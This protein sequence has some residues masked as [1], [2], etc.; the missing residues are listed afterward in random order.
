MA[1][2]AGGF[3]GCCLYLFCT[4]GSTSAVEATGP[5]I[6]PTAPAIGPSGWLLALLIVIPAV[7]VGLSARPARAIGFK[8]LTLALGWTLIE[9]VLVT[10]HTNTPEP[11]A[12]ARAVSRNREPRASARAGLQSQDYSNTL[13]QG[14][15]TGSQAEAPHLHWLARLLGYVSTAFLV[16]CANASLVGILAGARLSFP[17]QR[18]LSGSLN[19]GAWAPSQVVL[20][21]Q[22]WTLRQAYPRAPPI[23]VAVPNWNKCK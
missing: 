1:A 18:S 16:A 23:L 14:L 19:A 7:Y 13:Q 12:S 17:P 6:D 8:L 20:S 11:Q 4:A 15:L 10:T 21:I 5:A 3:W 9:A 22:A 2:L